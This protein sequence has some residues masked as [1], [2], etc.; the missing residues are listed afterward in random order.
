[1]RLYIHFFAVR[2]SHL[3][4]IF[5]VVCVRHCMSVTLVFH[6]LSRVIVSTTGAEE[7]F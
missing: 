6:V 5:F 1:M 3:Y 4:S 2:S 7:A